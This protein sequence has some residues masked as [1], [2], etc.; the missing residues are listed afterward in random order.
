MNTI[1][2]DNRRIVE[3]LFGQAGFIRSLGL[4]LAAI[5]SG[6]AE[7]RLTVRNDHLQ[8]DGYIHA[9][10]QATVADHTAGAAAATVMAAGCRVLTVEFKIN[11]LRPALGEQLFCR[12]GLLR[13][14]RQLSV[15]EAEVYGVAADGER[16]LTAKATVTLVAQP[17][18]GLSGTQS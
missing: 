7:T 16:R 15:A 14:G 1:N 6:R 4:E 10:V 18:A 9:G 5:E 13:A 12:A 11:L 17:I 8:Q 3:A 2:P